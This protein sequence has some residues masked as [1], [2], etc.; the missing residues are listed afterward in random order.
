MTDDNDASLVVH[1]HR[2]YDKSALELAAGT[3]DTKDVSLYTYIASIVFDVDADAVAQGQRNFVKASLFGKQHGLKPET[4]LTAARKHR[5]K[6][7]SVNFG[8]IPRGP[9]FETKAPK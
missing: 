4:I 1:I 8:H 2:V 6:A 7:K 5:I 3:L 9:R